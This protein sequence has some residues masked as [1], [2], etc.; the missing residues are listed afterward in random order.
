MPHYVCV[1]IL[2]ACFSLV[3]LTYLVYF[4]YHS[5][6]LNLCHSFCR[7][8]HDGLNS[9][10]TR[11]KKFKKAKMLMCAIFSGV[12]LEVLLSSIKQLLEIVF[13]V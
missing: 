10:E 2:A 9:P 4:P 6:C 1:I 8:S 11:Q 7:Q 12:N 13:I 5:F 3:L